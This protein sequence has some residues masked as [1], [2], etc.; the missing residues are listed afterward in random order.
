[1]PEARMQSQPLS[2]LPGT[3]LA[4]IG[5]VLALVGG[6]KMYLNQ[7][8]TQEGKRVIGVVTASSMRSGIRYEFQTADG[9]TFTGRQSRYS[10]RPGETILLEYLA[11][12]PSWNR[13]AGS[14]QSDR[15][16]FL[17]IGIVGVLTLL[18]GL[19]SIA[20]VL[21]RRAGADTA[22]MTP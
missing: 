11:S 12:D 19:Y 8:Y 18:A 3:L 7:R 10:G 6:G 9:R 14:E 17:P 20:Y 13:V 21:R 15:Q 16:S 2:V 4:L 5:L 22:P 1:M